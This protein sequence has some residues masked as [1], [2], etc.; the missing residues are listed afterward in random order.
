MICPKPRGN[1]TRIPFGAYLVSKNLISPGELEAALLCQE[2]RNPKLG[3]LAAKRQLLTFQK[4]REVY[5]YQIHTGLAFG[6]AAIDLGFLTDSEVAQLLEEQSLHHKMLG[7]ILV[8]LNII[9]PKKM[10][11]LLAS[12]FKEIGE[13]FANS[14]QSPVASSP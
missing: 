5:A 8:E 13:L 4:V 1:D 2:E 7:E 14:E 11:Q 3:A 6:K 10:E 12:Y 9:S